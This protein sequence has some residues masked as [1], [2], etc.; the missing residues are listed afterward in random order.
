MVKIMVKLRL[1]IMKGVR[2]VQGSGVGTGGGGR[3]GGCPL[4]STRGA[5]PPKI[6]SLKNVALALTIQWIYAVCFHSFANHSSL[7]VS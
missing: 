2:R 1:Y 4:K 3:G 5:L 6:Y 7:L